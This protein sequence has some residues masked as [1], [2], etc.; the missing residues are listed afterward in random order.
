MPSWRAQGQE[1][2]FFETSILE[3]EEI[4]L[5]IGAASYPRQAES[6][7][8]PIGRPQNW[9]IAYQTEIPALHLA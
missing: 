8:T 7:A 6:S 1:E 4:R 5:P 3:D 9:H 2:F